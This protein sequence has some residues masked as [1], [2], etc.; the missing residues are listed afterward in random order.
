[1]IISA[2]YAL[3]GNVA[4]RQCSSNSLREYAKDVFGRFDEFN[5]GYLTLEDFIAFCL[6]VKEKKLQKKK[7]LFIY[8]CFLKDPV[9]IQSI[10]SL[11]ITV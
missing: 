2:V 7:Y 11:R 4:N 3:L 9:L 6:K 5:R 8:F 10:E 1:M